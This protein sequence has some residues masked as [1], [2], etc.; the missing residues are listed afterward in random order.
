[1]SRIRGI[2]T[3]PRL[4]KDVLQNQ[5]WLKNGFTNAV[6][7]KSEEESFDRDDAESE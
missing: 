2:E 1:M 5:Q 7:K 3:K 6:R 4:Q